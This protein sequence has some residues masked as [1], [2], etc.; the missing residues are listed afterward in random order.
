M[1]AERL[2]QLVARAER[3]QGHHLTAYKA[4]RA[5]S[6]EELAA[7]FPTFDGI[8]RPPGDFE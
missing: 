7:L 1:N 4:E 8:I 6:I 5:R 2:A 3:A